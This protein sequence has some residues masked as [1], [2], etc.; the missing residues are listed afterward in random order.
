ML[1]E[2]MK[3][4]DIYPLVCKLDTVQKNLTT[5]QQ[6]EKNDDGNNENENE[7]DNS[8]NFKFYVNLI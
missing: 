8:T 7:N 3:N 2:N 4:L 6:E 1:N 5:T